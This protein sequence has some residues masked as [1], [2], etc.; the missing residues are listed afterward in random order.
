M[1]WPRLFPKV[2]KD[3][4]GSKISF[5]FLILIA[6]VS[7]IR[8]L[9]RVIA[10]TLFDAPSRDDRTELDWV[11]HSFLA[12]SPFGESE[13]IVTPLIG[14]SWGFHI[15]DDKNIELK[16]ISVLSAVDWKARLPYLRDCYKEW[17]F[18]EMIMPMS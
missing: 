7:A 12:A 17:D 1:D 5:Y 9:I 14:F 8:S 6:I 4:T 3:Y 15:T 2:E 13:R 18:A 10:P 11:A 16:P